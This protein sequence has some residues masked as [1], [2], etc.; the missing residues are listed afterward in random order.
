MKTF[1]L[2]DEPKIKSGFKTPENY[3]DNV[4]AKIMQQI[5][6]SETK[7]IPLYRRKAVILIAA[8][9]AIIVAL[10]IPIVNSPD[11]SF[12]ELDDNTMETYLSYQTNII[13][14]DLFN[15]LDNA[16]LK[17]M[18]DPIALEEEMLED[19]LSSNPYIEN[20]VSE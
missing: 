1:K 3:F 15:E 4:S 18:N 16:D 2:E 5:E 17:K 13:Q 19:I 7:V 9:A 20:L 12:I 10:M 11:N 14:Y 8:A 6:G